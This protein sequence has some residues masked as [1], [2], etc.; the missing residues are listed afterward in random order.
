M[1]WLMVA[2]TP[3]PIRCLIILL[4]CSAILFANSRMVITSGILTSLFTGFKWSLF[5]S[6]FKSL[7]S[8]CFALLNEAKL[9]P[10]VSVSSSLKALDI[11]NFNSRFFEPNLPF[12]GSSPFNLLVAR[13]SANFLFSKWL[14]GVGDGLDNTGSLEVIKVFDLKEVSC[15]LVFGK[16]GLFPNLPSFFSI[17]TEFFPFD[18][19]SSILLMV[20]VELPEIVNF[21][22]FFSIYHLSIL[23]NFISGRHN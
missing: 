17:I 1:L 19:A 8:F 11:V 15:L 9:L 10:L 13:C 4:D 18:F 14:D 2:V 16:R 12:W 20:F 21:V 5:S 3:I 23:I 7:F 22:F 6:F